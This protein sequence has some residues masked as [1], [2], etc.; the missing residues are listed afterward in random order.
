MLTS[1]NTLAKAMLHA[2]AIGATVIS[3][4]VAQDTG[5]LDKAAADK[6]YPAKPPYSPYA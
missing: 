1:R 4:A 3:A 5:T 2:L 6:A